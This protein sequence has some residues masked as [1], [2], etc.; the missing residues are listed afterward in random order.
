MSWNLIVGNQGAGAQGPQGFQGVP[1]SGG[2]VDGYASLVYLSSGATSSINW[3]KVPID[4]I[5]VDEGSWWDNTNKYFLPNKP[6]WYLVSGRASTGTVASAIS[7]LAV[8]KNGSEFSAMGNDTG[9]NQIAIGGSQIIYL[10]GTTDYVELWAYVNVSG[11]SYVTGAFDTYFQIIGPLQ[12]GSQGAQGDAG[13]PGIQ[14]AQ[15]DAGPQGDAGAQG[16]NTWGSITGVL[17]SQTDLQ[18]ALDAKQ[19]TILAN[20]QEIY[21]NIATGNDASGNGSIAS[22]YQTLHYAVST[23]T[24]T[25]LYYVINLSNGTY[26]GAPLTIPGNI[27]LISSRASLQFDVTMG[28]WSG[29]NIYPLYS[30][31][32][33]QNFYMDL[34]L[35]SIALPV[36]FNDSLN[37]TRI[38]ATTGPYYFKVIGGTV[39]SINLTGNASVSD[40]LFTATATIQ[41]G[42]NLLMHNC[43]IGINID[44]YSGGSLSMIGCTFIGSITALS[45]TPTINSDSTSLNYGG[46]IIG[47]LT[48]YLD[49]ANSIKYTPSTPANW[50]A[51]APSKINDALDLLA[52][53]TTSSGKRHF[54]LVINSQSTS[55]ISGNKEI[56]GTT[57]LNLSDLSASY[58]TATLILNFETSNSSYNAN[59][60][61]YDWDG[62]TNGGTPIII[63]GTNSSTNAT[64]GST[65]SINVNYLVTSSYSLAGLFRLRL[66]TDNASASA[67]CNFA[68]LE[69]A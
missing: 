5:S 65:S 39:E 30:G 50:G 10:N 66:W 40:V 68:R 12:S 60:D 45:G 35:A 36:F 52:A 58:T 26:T 57:Y 47:C 62:T 8:G 43:V 41:N 7:A 37:I 2:G 6:G 1:G 28:V 4:T 15:G 18:N 46:T 49:D 42:G 24:N 38:D 44:V 3:E 32:S 61:L 51:T 34:S 31:I 9:T 59:I 63:T 13:T 55:A 19:N 48:N 29:A 64:V 54:D 14:G 21:V 20:S 69:F 53:N 22:P 27:S 67:V 16:V 11:V 25:S 33:F 17:S 23:C 56:I